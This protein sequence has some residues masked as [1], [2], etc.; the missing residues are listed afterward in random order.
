MEGVS[1]I[2]TICHVCAS[3]LYSNHL[4]YKFRVDNRRNIQNKPIAQE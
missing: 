3:P 2:E 1:L 4:E